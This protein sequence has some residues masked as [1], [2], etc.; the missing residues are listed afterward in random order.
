MPFCFSSS[1]NLKCCIFHIIVICTYQL[2]LYC[3]TIVLTI[4][5]YCLYFRLVISQICSSLYRIEWVESKLHS[6]NPR[7]HSPH[8]LFCAWCCCCVFFFLRQSN[9]FFSSK[10][11][12]SSIILTS[13]L[14]YRR[15]TQQQKIRIVVI[16]LPWKQGHISVIK[17]KEG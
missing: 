9:H 2:L 17:G 15:S 12:T 10:N 6:L 11:I 16:I 3:S 8:Y 1:I 4:V 5:K 14:W 7:V 13:N